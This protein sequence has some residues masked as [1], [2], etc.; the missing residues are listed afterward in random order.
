MKQYT[1]CTKDGFRVAVTE[2]G[3]H[4][5]QALVFLHGFS[6]SATAYTEMLE[7]LADNGFHVYAVDLPDHGGS[8]SLPWGHT[9]KDMAEVIYRALM[10]VVTLEGLRITV[11]GHSM[12]GWVAAELAAIPRRHSFSFDEVILL[13][14]AVGT[15]FHDGIQLQP[16]RLAQFA[17][18]GLKDILGDARKAGSI[19]TL[20]ER[21]SLVSRLGSS[22][23]GPGI[24]RAAYAMLRSDSAEALKALRGKARTHIFHGSE[25]GIVPWKAALSASEAL[26]CPVTCL[27]GRYH[28]WMISDPELALEVIRDALDL[29]DNE[30]DAA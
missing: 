26:R 14:A 17:A 22:V 8:D 13:D 15:E 23:S 2:Y 1:T 27:A 11:V 16:K 3:D 29:T 12:G 25:D 28:S 4:T 6:V 19:R 10:H 7:L 24:A 5:G 9:V 21:L 30:D 20:W 18:G